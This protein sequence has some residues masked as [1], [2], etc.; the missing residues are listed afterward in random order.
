[1]Q[2]A[3]AQTSVRTREA[4]SASLAVT[5]VIDGLFAQ[6]GG[7]SYTVPALAKALAE[8]DVDVR[9]RTVAPEPS[10]QL[11]A[12]NFK[13]RVH[14][15]TFGS[16][17]GVLRASN[18]LRR[19]LLQDAREGAVL[20][21]HCLWLMPNI[22]PAWA[23]RSAGGAARLVH[24]VRGMLS[25][26]ALAISR[27]KKLPIWLLLQKSA[28]E[29]ADCL[30][31]TADAEY[32]EIRRAGLKNPVAVIPNAVE[33]HEFSVELEDVAREKKV[34]S[35][36]RLHPKKGLD[37]LIQAWSHVEDAFPDWR[38][39][40][41]GSAELGYDET[42]RALARSL[43]CRRISIEGP[44]YGDAKVAAYRSA[45][46]FVLSSINENFAITVAEALSAETPV[47]STKGA[48]WSGLEE[49]NC[50]WWIEQGAE[51][52][53]AALRTAMSMPAQE[54]RAMGLRGRL[55]MAQEYSWPRVA[56]DMRDVYRWLRDGGEPPKTVRLT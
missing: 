14:R 39:Q 21:A 45:E 16:S 24:S 42:L 7:P 26:E 6:H 23:R 43:N 28:L 17:G 12:P 36:G 34:L 19:A 47:I 18:D 41:V 50:G 13:H 49:R 32:E 22:Y 29:A 25:R 33:T 20:H 53:A 48:P 31:A 54:R 4:G 11:G 35:L 27:W 2:V 3:A 44:L 38:L 55:W 52:M 10:I 56:A 30:H 40:M 8:L 15:P 51:P 9:L 37:R 5:H 1:M 46:L